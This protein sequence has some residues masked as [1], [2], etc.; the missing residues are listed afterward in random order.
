MIS[1]HDVFGLVYH[2]FGGSLCI[3]NPLADLLQTPLKHVI[4]LPETLDSILYEFFGGEV[5][6]WWSLQNCSQNVVVI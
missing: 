4:C 5:G 1:L 3:F 2:Y 6:Y